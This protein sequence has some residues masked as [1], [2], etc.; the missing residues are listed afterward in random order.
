MDNI[1]AYAIQQLQNYNK[2]FIKRTILL[3]KPWT[4]I[5]EEQ[6]VQKLIFKSNDELIISKNGDVKRGKWE[7][8]VE[9]K[10]FLIDRGED[11]I[12]CQ[13]GFLDEAALILRKDGANDIFYV[14]ANENLLPDLNVKEYLISLK[15]KSMN[16]SVERVNN[17]KRIEI[18]PTSNKPA[19]ISIGSEVSEDLKKISDGKYN[20]QNSNIEIHVIDSC[21]V[22][23][24][25][26]NQYETLAGVVIHIEQQKLSDYEE[27]DKV[28]LNNRP[29]P[30]GKYAIRNGFSFTVNEG[31]IFQKKWFK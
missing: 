22:N 20:I 15:Y 19:M 31:I 29:A 11:I 17:G 6:Q 4:L 7:Y 9:A 13:E 16:L 3:N 21:I 23:I 8:L 5:D 18:H 26:R 27:G 1:Y 24:V 10:S 12:L 28:F 25:Y 14:F 2:G 30:D